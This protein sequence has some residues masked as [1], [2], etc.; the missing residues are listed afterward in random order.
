[1]ACRYVASVCQQLGRLGDAEGEIGSAA[2]RYG[3][4]E[5]LGRIIGQ[6]FTPDAQAAREWW[7]GPRRAQYDHLAF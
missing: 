7:L 4:T 5:A 3:A 2:L 6:P 1:L